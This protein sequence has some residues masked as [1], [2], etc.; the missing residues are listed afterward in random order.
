M[1]KLLFKSDAQLKL[2]TGATALTD[3]V[4]LTLGPKSKSVLIGKKWGKPIVCNDGVTIAKEM[5]L[6]DPVENM[7]VQMLREV[8]ELTGDAVGDG[9]STSTILAHAIFS[10]GLKNVTAGASAIDLK[11]GLERGLIVAVSSIK[12]M[13]KKITTRQEKEQVATIS[14]HN[15]QN[16][17]KFV[18]DAIEKVGGEGIVTVEEARGIETV[19]EVVEGMQFDR[20]YL[21]PYFITD[22][23]KMETRFDSPYILIYEKKISSIEPLVPILEQLIKTGRPLLIIAEE[24]EGEALAMLVVNKLRS[25]LACAAVKA[26]GFGDPRKEML[27]DIAALT[28]GIFY[29]EELGQKIDKLRLEDLGQAD[30]VIIGKESTTIVG[31]HGSK[32]AIKD[33]IEQLKYRIQNSKSDYVK[34]KLKER[35]GK[36]TGGIAVVR[37]GAPSESELKSKKEALD[38]AIAAT[39]AAVS[40]GVVPGAG[41][42]LLRAITAL[43]LEETKMSGDEK[44]GIQILRHALEAPTRQIAENSGDDGGVV[45]NKMRTGTGNYGYDA[46]N[47]KF[48]DLVQ[49]GI[50]DPTKVVRIALENA[51]SVAS[52]LLLTQATLTEE[53]DKQSHEHEAGS[54]QTI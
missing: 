10:E 9:T 5:E 38:D 28:G 47:R 20:G 39:K 23:A 43:E 14:A 8:A 15:D 24:V 7:G 4:R 46:S 26:P 2:L 52:I 35:L 42:A 25:T 6:E 27:E 29:S 1:K 32:Q 44:T 53:K 40:E 13:S 22:A 34:E 33:R 41:L 19:V 50:I 51:V 48:V 31:G 12:A 30:K 17:G 37:V 18:A 11:R 16:I 45:V 54:M 49:E 21:S 3:A 36:L